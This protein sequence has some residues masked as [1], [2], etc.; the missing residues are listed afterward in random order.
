[1]D[2][3]IDKFVEWTNKYTELYPLNE[4]IENPCIWQ[5]IYRQELYTYFKVLIYIGLTIKPAIKDYWKD[6]NIYSTE[7][8]IK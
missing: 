7:Y 2:K 6:L 5:L 4:E 1:M 8:I 3:I